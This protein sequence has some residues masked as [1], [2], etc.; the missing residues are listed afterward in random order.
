[1]VQC[2]LDSEKLPSIS[3][4]KLLLHSEVFYRAVMFYSI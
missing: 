4:K 2:C 3:S 1:V